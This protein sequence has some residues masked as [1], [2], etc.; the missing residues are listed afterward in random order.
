MANIPSLPVTIV[1][2]IKSGTSVVNSFYNN[3]L[4]FYSGYP[5]TFSVTLEIVPTNNSDD[6]ILPNIYSY[7]AN[8]IKE[9]M[10]IGQSNGFSYKIIDVSEPTNSTEVD[11]ILKDVNLYNLLSDP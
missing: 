9:G 2:K 1:G 11:V 7:D 4:S 3:S 5:Y 10:W 8:F 6:R